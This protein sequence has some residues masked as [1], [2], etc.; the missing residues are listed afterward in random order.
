[1]FKKIFSFFF[2]VISRQPFIFI[3][4]LFRGSIIRSS[5]FDVRVLLKSK[6]VKT[7]VGSKV[8][9]S[10]RVGKYT[11]IGVDSILF[12]GTQLG[13]YSSVGNCCRIGTGDHCIKGIVLNT[14]LLPYGIGHGATFKITCLE[15]DVW[16]GNSASIK[17]GVTIGRS[18]IIGMGSV[19]LK[20]VDRYCISYGYPAI[21][22]KLR[23]SADNIE[24]IEN[25]RWWIME[26]KKAAQK[27]KNGVVV[28]E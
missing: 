27:I 9:H 22:T 28:S 12:P 19:V 11:F 23:L 2:S 25:T 5:Y 26:P 18:S 21:N 8:F 3:I 10:V 14:R 15:E 16:V 24:K 17:G 4:G 1:M 13:E 6:S 7:E 20:N